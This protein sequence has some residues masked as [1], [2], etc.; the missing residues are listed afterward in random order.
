MPNMLRNIVLLLISLGLLFVAFT[1]FWFF[2]LLIA[3]GLVAR[4]AYLKLFKKEPFKFHTYTVRFGSQKHGP[5]SSDGN[6]NEY[7]EYI[8]VIDADD[9]TKEYRVPR[10][11]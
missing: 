8:T 9:M 11:K 7:N 5:Y 4:V 6:P 2:L 3:I 10:I 1:F